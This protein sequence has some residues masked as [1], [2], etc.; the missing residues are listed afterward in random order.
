M[1]HTGKEGSEG[2][3]HERKEKD[4][5]KEANVVAAAVEAL[6]AVAGALDWTHYREL[7]NLFM[8]TMQRNDSKVIA[9]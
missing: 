7:L 3:G 9:L 5:D 8:R 1:A 4:R 2:A 6:S